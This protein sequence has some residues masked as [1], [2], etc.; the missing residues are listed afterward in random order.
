MSNENN[1]KRQRY[2]IGIILSNMWALGTMLIQSPYWIVSAIVSL[3]W[4][5]YA[6]LNVGD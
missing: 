5:V 6:L 2:L 4:A 3:F 1:I